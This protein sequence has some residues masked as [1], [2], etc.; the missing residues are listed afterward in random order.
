MQAP[1]MP[2]DPYS[3]Q[4]QR[5]SLALGIGIGAV[6]VLIAVGGGMFALKLFGNRGGA[7]L[8]RVVAPQPA[9]AV[10]RETEPV[11]AEPKPPEVKMPDDIYSWLE[12]L[13]ITEEKRK[14]LATDQMGDLLVT[15]SQIQSGG[16]IMDAIG[17]IFGSDPENSPVDVP[18]SKV[19]RVAEEAENKRKD[20]K[21]LKNFFL[22]IPPPAE[23]APIQASYAQCLGET[24]GMMME[25]LDAVALA[26]RDPQAAIGALTRMKGQ[27]SKRI[28][29]LGRQTDGQVQDIC[30]KYQT[31]KWFTIES[32]FGGGVL[33][34]IPGF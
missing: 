3:Q 10:P 6:A 27:S 9:T 23:C 34:K 33:G 11:L 14:R 21:D 19:N 18:Q 4:I 31:R 26:D 7:G 8:S 16:A 1:Q 13:R 22:S 17:S 24:G 28:D 20:W 25:I 30:D 5:S 2:R 15:M 32:D 29:A 12:H